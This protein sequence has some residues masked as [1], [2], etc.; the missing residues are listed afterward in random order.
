MFLDER[1]LGK[2]IWEILWKQTV[3]SIAGADGGWEQEN[4]KE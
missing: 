2:K 3:K 1:W 4:P